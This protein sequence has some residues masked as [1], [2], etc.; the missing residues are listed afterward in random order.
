MGIRIEAVATHAGRRGRWARGAT[1][2][3]T[4]AARR[5]LSAAGRTP[6]DVD[7]LLW[8]GVYR[9]DNVCEPA[10]AP[11]VQR[12][13]GA[14]HR[15]AGD[16]APTGFA[17][18]V[19]EGGA[20][21]PV[22]A[23]V[24]GRFLTCGAAGCALVVC[25]DV[26]PTPG[27]SRGADFDPIGGALLLGSGDGE[28]DF[29]A[30]RQDTFSKHAHLRESRVDFLGPPGAR[31][32][33]HALRVREDER[34]GAEAARCVAE[35]AEALLAETGLRPGDVDLVV[36]GTALP[37]LP[38]ALGGLGIPAE[39]VCAAAPL[40]APVTGAVAALEAAMASP[41]WSRARRVLWVAVGAGITVS[42]A[43]YRTGRRD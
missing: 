31:R 17:F 43:L 21:M 28:E 40:R 30:F 33:H 15:F 39:R 5:A 32:S 27:R 12:R 41:A 35:S 26:D 1:A 23:D 29:E 38:C 6:S 8:S 9:D 2:L 7:L 36:P 25:G 24:A 14:R 34:F 19:V 4:A 37:E 13:L 3:A 11:F 18:D 10:I 20:G 16:D 22:A 42:L